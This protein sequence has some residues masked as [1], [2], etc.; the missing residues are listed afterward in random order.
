MYA[1]KEISG[2]EKTETQKKKK[3]KHEKKK[4]KKNI[5]H[6]HMN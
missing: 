6:W 5:K 4:K 2:D 3:K 1:F